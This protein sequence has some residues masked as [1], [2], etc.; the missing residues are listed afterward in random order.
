MGFTN[1][2]T[3]Q[4]GA[5]IRSSIHSPNYVAGSTGWTIN[6]DG[7][8]EFNSGTFRG[9]V[10]LSGSGAILEYS[11]LALNGL[12]VA[13]APSAGSDVYGNNYNPGLNLFDGSGNATGQWGGLTGFTIQD[14]GNVGIKMNV[15]V[16]MQVFYR[17]LPFNDNLPGIIQGVLSDV[18]VGRETFRIDGP[19]SLAS[20]DANQSQVKLKL[21]AG[22]SANGADGRFVFTSSGVDMTLFQLTNGKVTLPVGATLNDKETINS[23]NVGGALAI[24][25]SV[26]TTSGPGTISHQESA[27]TNGAYAVFVSGDAHTRFNWRADGQ[28]KWGSGAASPDTFLERTAAGMLGV[29]TGSFAVTTAGQGLRVKEGTNAKQGTATLAAGTVTVANTSVTANSRILLTIQIPGGAVGAVYVSAVVAGTSFTIKSTSATD[30][31]TVA[32]LIMEPA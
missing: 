5:L 26:T 18:L 24:V 19:N 6:K 29:T 11:A 14:A 10:V 21:T 30:T 8:V 23:S 9:N 1:P 20:I 25:Q 16:P 4:N 27:A 22:N 15:S 12:I 13:L 7:T 2:I 28:L 32:Y 17:N 3:G 31:S